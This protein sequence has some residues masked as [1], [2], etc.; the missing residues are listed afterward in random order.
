MPAFIDLTGRILGDWEVMRVGS[1]K[2]IYWL[3]KCSCGMTRL[4]LA[5]SLHSGRS[6][7]CGCRQYA[8]LIIRQLRHGHSQRRTKSRAYTIWKHMKGR[9]LNENNDDFSYYGGRGISVCERWMVFENFHED[10]GDPPLG[11]SIDR[12]P[13]KNGNYEKSNCRWATQG[14]QVENRRSYAE[15][16]Y[17]Q[18]RG[19]ASPCSKLTVEQREKIC[20]TH[21]LSQ[22]AI[23]VIYGVSQA[24]ISNLMNGKV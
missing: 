2:P 8:D 1:F 5:N 20:A 4:V 9:C 15:T 24:T 3:C 14:Q 22:T 11:K 21:G 10:M 19:A 13:D 12:F 18:P 17:R 23:A 7:G 16:G 6:T